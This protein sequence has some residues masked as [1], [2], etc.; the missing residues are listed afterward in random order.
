MSFP[1]YLSFF[2]LFFFFHSE[3]IEHF[4]GKESRKSNQTEAKT[5]LNIVRFFEDIVTVQ[6][7]WSKG[8]TSIGFG[9]H[10]V[11]WWTWGEFE[12]VSMFCRFVFNP[13]SR[14][15]EFC[16]GEDWFLIIVVDIY[17]SIF[18]DS[19]IVVLKINYDF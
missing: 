7:H 17:R 3:K 6:F 4:F 10:G 16:R 9:F 5:T 2:F 15:F 19:L 18:E 8:E 11:E 14:K 12:V 1:P 13:C